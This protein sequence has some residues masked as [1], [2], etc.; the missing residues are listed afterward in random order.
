LNQNLN[1][2]SFG[3]MSM[4]LN[5]EHPNGRFVLKVDDQAQDFSLA[6]TDGTVVS[7]SAVLERTPAIIVFYRGD[8]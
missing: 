4:L 5:G 6:D 1:R 8:W 3:D 2:L 7:L